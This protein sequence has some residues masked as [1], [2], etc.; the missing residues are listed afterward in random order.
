MR[1]RDLVTGTV[2]LVLAHTLP[3]LAQ[4]KTADAVRAEIRK[5]RQETL[6]QLYKDVP[7]ARRNI[8]GAAGYA[9]FES[10]GAQVLFVGGAGGSGV[11]RDNLTGKDTYMKMASAGVGLGLGVKDMRVIFVFKKRDALKRFVEDGWQFGGQSDVAAKADQKGGAAGDLEVAD[12]IT[13]YQLT[14]SGL[15]AQATVQG[16]KYWKDDALN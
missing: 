12:G 10:V 14:Q 7:Q 3:A 5:M 9:V 2:A 4:E 8:R 11:V 15:I 6:D 13:V 1:R 16:T